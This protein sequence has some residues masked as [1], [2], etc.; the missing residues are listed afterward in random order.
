[1]DEIIDELDEK[2][3][4]L[5]SYNQIE[6]QIKEI[7]RLK[8]VNTKLIDALMEISK[9]KGRA[10]EIAV[11]ALSYLTKVASS[12]KDQRIRSKKWVQINQK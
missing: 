6:D 4:S 5:R 7:E 3:N 8:K 11:D 9:E 1:L 10:S 2:I 12:I